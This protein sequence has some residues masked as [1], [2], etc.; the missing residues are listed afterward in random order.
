[1]IDAFDCVVAA[2]RA[3]GI[4]RDN[5]L[6][7]PKLRGD[8]RFLRETTTQA[9]PGRRNAVIM[10]RRTWDSV[11][12]RFRP[13]PGRL[14]VVMS[15]GALA[16]GDEALVAGSLDDAL[17]RAGGEDDIERV[18]VLGGAEVFRA[19]FAD[20]RCR[21]VY[22]TRIDAVYACDT[23]LPAMDDFELVETIAAHHDGGVDYRIERWRRRG[24]PASTGAS[25]DAG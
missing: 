5:D 8:L 9:S 7:W 10:G 11:P 21:D 14:N 20:P 3:G 18:F 24:W 16:L 15:R 1:M 13:L 2:D 17:A 12:A 6:P 22:L 4:G 23:F 19:A 25:T